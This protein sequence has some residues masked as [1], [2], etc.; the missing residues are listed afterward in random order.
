MGLGLGAQYEANDRTPQ[1]RIEL[2]RKYENGV[3]FFPTESLLAEQV[4]EALA[5]L[6]Y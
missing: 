1:P 5:L 6:T 4:R 3:F 2:D